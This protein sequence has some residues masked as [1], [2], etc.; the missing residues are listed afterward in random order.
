[1]LLIYNQMRIV[2][3]QILTIKVFVRKCFASDAT[4]I[5]QRPIQS[6]VALR[7]RDGV[8]GI[9]GSSRITP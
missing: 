1:M 5:T 7:A 9:G 2:M 8:E 3:R 6:G 4:C